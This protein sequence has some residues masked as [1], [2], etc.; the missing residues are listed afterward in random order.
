MTRENDCPFKAS[1]LSPQAIGV[2]VVIYFAGAYPRL[3]ISRVYLVTLA[4]VA[5]IRPTPVH[6]QGE[7]SGYSVAC[8]KFFTG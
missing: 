8:A 2:S 5:F 4:I 7:P 1:L 6:P 3:A